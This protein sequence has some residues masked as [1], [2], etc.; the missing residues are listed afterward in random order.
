LA[1]FAE[2]GLPG[3]LARIPME[4]FERA[5]RWLARQPAADPNRIVS[6]GVSR[7]GEA[8]LLIA[9]MFPDLVHAAVGYVPSDTIVPSPFDASTP[10]WT[11]HGKAPGGLIRVERINGPV[12]IVGGDADA[13]W[14]SGPSVRNMKRRMLRHG[15]HDITAL[16]YPKAGHGIGSVLP[17]MVEISPLGYGVVQTR[18]GQ[19]ILG[20]SPRA[21]EAALE[22]SWPKLLAFMSRV[23]DGR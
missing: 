17:R 20:G 7:G 6:F 8:S 21:D 2:P 19:L 15:R 23:G 11:Y 14:P 10:A 13:L 4:Y 1:Y 5:L 9:S 12:F 18:Y 16:D 22:D 3:S